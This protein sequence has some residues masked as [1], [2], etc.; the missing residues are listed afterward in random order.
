MRGL[1]AQEQSGIRHRN[2]TSS[3]LINKLIGHGQP[4]FQGIYGGS[5]RLHGVTQ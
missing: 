2:I 1:D 5:E 4:E 3:C